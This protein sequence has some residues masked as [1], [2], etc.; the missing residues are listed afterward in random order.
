MAHFKRNINNNSPILGFY[1]SEDFGH[2]RI[3]I[4]NTEYLAYLLNKFKQNDIS[5]IENTAGAE[6]IDG[7]LKA[8]K[9]PE[10]VA[11]LIKELDGIDKCRMIKLHKK[12]IASLVRII[13][14]YNQ[15]LNVFD[16]ET[17]DWLTAVA[18][19]NGGYKKCSEDYEGIKEYIEKD[20]F[21]NFPRGVSQDD[22]TRVRERIT[23]TRIMT[24]NIVANLD[25]H[26]FNIQNLNSVP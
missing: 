11:E 12:D 14:N 18:G 8:V 22:Y 5:V 19:E 17:R 6:F 10:R 21:K 7:L 2:V 15:G 4:R 1:L 3:F 13:A 20:D 24:I 23:L 9:K 16:L 25:Q 26:S